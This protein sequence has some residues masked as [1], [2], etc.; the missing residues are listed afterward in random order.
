MKKYVFFLWFQIRQVTISGWQPWILPETVI[1]K[2][3]TG[4]KTK[5]KRKKTPVKTS[6]K[7][8]HKKLDT[9]TILLQNH[10]DNLD[11]LIYWTQC[12]NNILMHIIC[13]H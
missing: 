1:L 11:I 3:S 9:S 6:T 4:K 7:Y 2:T 8:L 10:K 13:E 12:C 5:K